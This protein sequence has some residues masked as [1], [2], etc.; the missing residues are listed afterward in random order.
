MRDKH[1]VCQTKTSW[2]CAPLR[3]SQTE[4][5]KYITKL[6]VIKEQAGHFLSYNSPSMALIRINE[7]TV[8][9]QFANRP[10]RS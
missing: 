3:L 1:A 7:L 2:V 4:V 9:E 6:L 8:R 10:S 5:E